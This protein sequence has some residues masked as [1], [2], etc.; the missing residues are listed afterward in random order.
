MCLRAHGVK[1]WHD[2]TGGVKCCADGANQLRILT[3]STPL[4]SPRRGRGG[5]TGT[6]VNLGA[7]S[8]ASSQMS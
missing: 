2:V 5:D 3:N 7:E 1:T 8:E 6:E 4:G